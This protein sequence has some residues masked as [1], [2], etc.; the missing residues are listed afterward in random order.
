MSQAILEANH[1]LGLD[2]AGGT[3]DR[4][5]G[6][7]PIGDNLVSGLDGLDR[8]GGAVGPANRRPRGKATVADIEAHLASRGSRVVARIIGIIAVSFRRNAY[9]QAGILEIL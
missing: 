1:R 3:L 6:A 8:H 2:T 7:C 5:Y 4:E 9:D